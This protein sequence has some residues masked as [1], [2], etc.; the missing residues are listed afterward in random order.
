M[1][2]K[3]R[4]IPEGYE[5]ACSDAGRLE[6]LDVPGFSD[7]VV[8]LPFG[9][10]SGE[11]RYSSLY[12][13]HEG[14][15]SQDSFFSGEGKL[16]PLLDHMIAAGEI[17][18]LLV[19]TPTYYPPGKTGGEIEYSQEAVREFEEIFLKKIVPTVDGKYRTRTEARSRCLGGFAMGA[20]ATWYIMMMEGTGTFYWYL[21]MCGD[22]WICGRRGGDRHPA[23]TA[24]LMAAAM[25]GKSFSVNAYT[26]M[27]D[28][29]F[30]SLS[31]QIHAMREFPDVFSSNLKYSVMQEGTN[32]YPSVRR[33]LYNALPELFT[34]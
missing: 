32:D 24:G 4:E 14:C 2:K 1:A 26:G 23:Q 19:V 9:Y 25:Q 33:Y 17:S 30:P 5:T 16:K 20:V 27:R 34:R 8:Y 18:P 31:S 15:G 13:L 21:P 7:T 11:D 3:L 10:D 29:S 6:R 28:P 12:L 22:C